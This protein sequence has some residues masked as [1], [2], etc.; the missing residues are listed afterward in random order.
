MTHAGNRYIYTHFANGLYESKLPTYNTNFLTIHKRFH[1][2]IRYLK[3]A[4]ILKQLLNF[5]NFETVT[6]G[7]DISLRAQTLVYQ[8][9]DG[10]IR[11]YL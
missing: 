2:F 1:H 11:S 7:L 10:I 8:S 3:K 6:F 9:I 4:L 5:E